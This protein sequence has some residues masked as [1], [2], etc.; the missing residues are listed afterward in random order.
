MCIHPDSP[1]QGLSVSSTRELV[2]DELGIHPDPCDYRIMCFNNIIQILSCFCNVLGIFIRPVRHL[3]H[4]LKI[5]AHMVFLSVASCMIAQ[6]DYELQ[7]S[8]TLVG[9]TKAY[10]GPCR[11]EMIR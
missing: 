8:N 1:T 7:A 11:E 5:F 2:M 3:A 4:L 6:V 9:A 10:G